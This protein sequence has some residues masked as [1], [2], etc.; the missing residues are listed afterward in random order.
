MTN[1]AAI[2]LACMDCGEPWLLEQREREFFEG[3]GLACPKRCPRC[4]RLRREAKAAAGLPVYVAPM[5]EGN[6]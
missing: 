2:L 6:E 5:T 4:R 1:E 3:R